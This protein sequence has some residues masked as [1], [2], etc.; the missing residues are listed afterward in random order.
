MK[1]RK[2]EFYSQND[3]ILSEELKLNFSK[4]FY[5]HLKSINALVY[6]NGEI[7]ERYIKIKKGD[8]IEIIYQESMEIAWPELD[9]PL[10][11]CYEDEHYL[12]CY[13]EANMLT[14]PT[15]AC[16]ISLYQQI[17]FHLKDTKHISFLNRLDK[18][19]QG[20]VLIAKDTYSAN[21]LTPV[22]E[23]IKRKY[24]A[25]VK[26]NLSNSGTINKRIER[27]GEGNKRIISESGKVAITH[28][29]TIWSTETKSLVELELETGRTHQIRVHLASIGHPII[30]DMLYGD[31][32]NN[33][34]CLESYYLEFLNPYKK[35]KIIIKESLAKWK[36]K[37]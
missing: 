8:K 30:G 20:L 24:L 32:L 21:L 35:E 4:K 28:Y 17:L 11:I 2:I 22:K 33:I 27:S 25:L 9:L 10:K 23:N 16:P 5:R 36:E 37:E 19:T 31:V 6:V 14:I 29:K 34:M 3:N 26:G 18:E 13:K 15:K 1:E 7:K 12:I